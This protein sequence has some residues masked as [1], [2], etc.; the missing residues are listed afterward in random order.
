MPSK[1][2]IRNSVSSDSDRS[3]DVN[4]SI[5][6]NT[7]NDI[8]KKGGV[9]KKIKKDISITKST[10]RSGS[11][12]AVVK[13]ISSKKNPKN[14]NM[15]KFSSKK[16]EITKTLKEINIL[17]RKVTAHLKELERIHKKEMKQVKKTKKTTVKCS[18]IVKPAPVPA[19]LRHLLNLND[20]HLSRSDVSKL[21]Y[22]Y[23]EKNKLY[24][25]KTRKIII[26]NKAMKNVFGMKDNDTIKFENFQTWLKKVYNEN[27]S[28]ILDMND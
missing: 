13:G 26:P 3:D 12:N 18:G 23:I 14:N 24:S 9:D 4:D 1:K 17:T 22:R 7:C 2:D 16:E 11:K 8:K 21:V 27:D 19:S 20:T 15:D 6:T 28:L 25:P 10:K 5:E